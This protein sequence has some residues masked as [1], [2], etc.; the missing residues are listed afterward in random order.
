MVLAL[1]DDMLTET[2]VVAD[3]AP[4]LRVGSEA[5][6]RQMSAFGELLA[7]A[8]R[9][10][11]LVGGS[12]WTEAACAQVVAFAEA[13]GIPAATSFRRQDLFDHRSPCFAGDLGTSGPPALVQRVKDADL[14][15]VVGA[16]LGETTTQGYSVMASPRPRQRLIHV[17]ASADE[18]GRVFTPVLGI[19]AAPSA[20][21]GALRDVAPVDPARW[22]AWC[23]AARRDYVAAVVP[24]DYEGA[25]DL[26]RVMEALGGRLPDDAVVTLDA[27][28]HTGWPQ[29]Y[30]AYGRPGRQLGSTCGSMGYA[31]PAAVAAS[32][33]HPDRLVVGCVGDGGFMRC[34]TELATAIQHG[35]KPIILVFNNAMY[36]TIRMHQEREHPER[37]IGTDLRNPDFVALARS[38]GAHAEVVTRTDAFAAAFERAATCGRP[39]LIE[40]RTDPELLSTR[41]TISGLRARAVASRAEADT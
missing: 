34:G 23:Q 2:A 29:R 8:E 19:V 24:P 4:Y 3:A 10:L 17:H 30:L 13:A 12:G 7:G 31:V 27:G 21:A 28:N 9:P 32:L 40:L 41:A 35:G 14:L 15:V 37:V 39:A 6:S 18:I 20:F 25:L 22:R 26:P 1:P 11:L 5:S 38:L 33:I 36:G 16:R